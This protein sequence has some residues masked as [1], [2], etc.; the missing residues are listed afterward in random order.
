M[1]AITIGH[2]VGHVTK[3]IYVCWSAH[4]SYSWILWIISRILGLN[5]L[6]VVWTKFTRKNLKGNF[7]LTTSFYVDQ[8]IFWLMTTSL[9]V[10]QTGKL[11]TLYVR[12]LKSTYNI[13]VKRLYLCGQYHGSLISV[14][15]TETGSLSHKRKQSKKNILKVWHRLSSDSVLG[16]KD[17]YLVKW[18]NICTHLIMF[19]PWH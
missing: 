16:L 11:K 12:H 8:T 3:D 10:D 17:I 4:F 2:A 6:R 9:Y 13:W 14:N 7:A 5:I 15:G 1:L 19:L 18:P